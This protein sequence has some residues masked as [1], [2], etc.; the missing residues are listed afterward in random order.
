MVLGVWIAGTVQGTADA[1]QASIPAP[2]AIFAAQIDEEVRLAAR[3]KLSS[4]LLVI[5]VTHSTDEGD[6]RAGAL[7]VP[8]QLSKQI[9]SSDLVGPLEGGHVG[10]LLIYA[11]A[12]GVASAAARIRQ[13]LDEAAHRAGLP[14]VTLGLAA[15]SSTEQ[16]LAT[17]VAQARAAAARAQHRI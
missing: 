11:D 5:D 12:Q 17:V 10:V 15:F 3:L 9:S 13:R 14:A 6:A 1:E 8:Q 16:S 7:P 4:G 2:I